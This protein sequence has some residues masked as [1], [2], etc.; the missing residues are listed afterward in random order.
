MT[1]IGRGIIQKATAIPRGLIVAGLAVGVLGVL[2]GACGG[3]SQPPGPHLSLDGDT[4]DL[5]DI[6][7]GE[8]VQ[9][10]V[11]FRNDG[12]EPLTVTIAD[13]SVAPESACG[14]GVEGYSV[15]QPQVAPGA[16]GNLVFDLKVPEGTIAMKDV[17]LVEL[18]TN[19][20]EQGEHTITIKYGVAQ[21]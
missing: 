7:P 21:P 11:E 17:M 3:G 9:R 6:R 10:Q 15:D 16:T 20:P 18:Q 8:A 1:S 2:A 14:C 19:D 4:F 12:D 13:V 5:G